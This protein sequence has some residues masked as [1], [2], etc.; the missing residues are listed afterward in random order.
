MFVQIRKSF[1][2]Q[3][4][5][6]IRD[7]GLVVQDTD[8]ADAVIDRQETKIDVRIDNTPKPPIP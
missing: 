5:P 1:C 6:E 7:R 2:G 8:D 4:L 3:S